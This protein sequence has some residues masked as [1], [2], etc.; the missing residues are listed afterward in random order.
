MGEVLQ[1]SQNIGDITGI[2]GTIKSAGVDLRVNLRRDSTKA[3]VM[4]ALKDVCSQLR[5]STVTGTKLGM[6]MGHML[7]LVK[8]RKLYKPEFDT[9]DAFRLDLAAKHNLGASSASY[10][11][12]VAHYL[13]EIEP[14][15]VTKV[16]TKNLWMLARATRKL[17]SRRQIASL[18]KQAEELQVPEFREAL[19]EKGL[20]NPKK[21]TVL[22]ALTI[23]VPGSVLKQWRALVGDN[24]PGK[25]LRD[26]ILK[27]QKQQ[28]EQLPEAA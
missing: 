22:H 28:T 4:A 3:D 27:A 18:L 10:W 24:D 2:T 25:V 1:Q 12:A 13:P 23:R 5:R 15:Q 6:M 7:E 14:A 8:V 16:P 11:Q 17:S 19:E 20:L 21:G 26:L 9:F